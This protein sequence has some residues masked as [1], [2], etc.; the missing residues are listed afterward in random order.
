[1]VARKGDSE[2]SVRERIGQLLRLAK[3]HILGADAA[4]APKDRF[5]SKRIAM[6]NDANCLQ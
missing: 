1:V 2:A 3:I 4:L 5:R 6:K